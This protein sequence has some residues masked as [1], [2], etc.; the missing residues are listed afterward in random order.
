[1]FSKSIKATVMKV[2]EQK[3][4][5][6]QQAYETEVKTIDKVAETAKAKAFDATVENLVGKIL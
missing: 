6:A 5:K 4:A 2:I 1:M 3:I